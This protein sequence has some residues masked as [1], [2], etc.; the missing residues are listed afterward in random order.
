MTNHSH[1]FWGS[2]A[3]DGSFEALFQSAPLL[4]HSIDTKGRFLS[5]SQF[6]AD[7][8]GYR[9]EDM[10]GQPLVEFLS[11]ASRTYAEKVALPS[12]WRDG[13][14][15]AIEYEFLRKDG[16][17]LPVSLSAIAEYDASGEIVRSLAISFETAG[18]KDPAL[19]DA[20]EELIADFMQL[21]AVMRGSLF[22]PDDER[23]DK[24]IMIVED[25]VSMRR[26]LAR[27]LTGESIQLIE[28]GSGDDAI[29]AMKSGIRPDLLLTDVVM[30]GEVQGPDLANKARALFPDLRVLF[31]SGYPVEASHHAGD[32]NP[33]DQQLIKPVVHDTLLKT[34]KK[35]LATG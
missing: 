23:Q 11:T 22:D 18:V 6:L 9:V 34:V 16:G 24:K 27:C 13:S 26:Y 10:L 8:L 30:P 5:V 17:V 25:D 33:T 32:I 7:S 14:V 12:F 1:Q 15:K 2:L 3:S 21:L 31:M 4:L 19:S 29:E 28:A 20:A 35:M